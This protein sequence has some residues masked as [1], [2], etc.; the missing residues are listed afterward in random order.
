M[1][2][3]DSG[4]SRDHHRDVPGGGAVRS[5]PH[6]RDRPQARHRERRALPL[7]A[8]PRSDVGAMWGAEVAA[9]LV[10]ELCGGE[11][12]HV[13]GAGEMPSWRRRLSLRP[14]RIAA[15]GRRRGAGG[16]GRAHPAGAGLRG[17]ARRRSPEGPAALLA[18]RCG[19]RGRSRRGGGAG[20]GLS[21]VSRPSR[22][23]RT[24]RRAGPGDDAGPAPRRPCQ[25]P[26]GRARPAGGGHLLLHAP[27]LGRALRR[28]RRPALALA[29]PISADLDQM[30]P[31]LAAQSPGGGGTQCGARLW[32]CRAVRGRAAL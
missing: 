13:V 17:R 4:C 29:N 26:A 28:R 25:A 22:L 8:R 7:R 1:G 15:P 19:G 6:R 5:D 11:A 23:P 24:L 21:T 12:S 3:E 16:R 32:R 2:G 14:E 31:F 9:R 18:R 27:R 20:L 30:R 10:L